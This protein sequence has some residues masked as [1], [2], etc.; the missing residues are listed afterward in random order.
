ML[1]Q[2]HVQVPTVTCTRH[3]LQKLFRSPSA[4]SPTWCA[5]GGRSSGST[6]LRSSSPCRPWSHAM[7]RSS[8]L[9]SGPWSHVMA[10]S[11]PLIS[12]SWSDVMARSSSVI[13]AASVVPVRLSSRPESRPVRMTVRI[14]VAWPVPRCQRIAVGILVVAVGRRIIIVMRIYSAIVG[15]I[16]VPELVPVWIIPKRVGPVVCV[17]HIPRIVVGVVVPAIAHRLGHHLSGR[18]HRHTSDQ[19][20]RKGQSFSQCSQHHDVPRFLLF[21]RLS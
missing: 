5:S 4:S 11:A 20:E 16:V 12:G 7:T 3:P 1:L 14:T 19:E 9:I 21:T 18:P 17:R 10:R 13:P 15:P 6:S 2:E 8:P